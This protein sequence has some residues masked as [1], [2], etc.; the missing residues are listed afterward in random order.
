[1]FS[2]RR[3]VWAPLWDGRQW[4]DGREIVVRVEDVHEFLTQ[5][6]LRLV[7]RLAPYGTGFEVEVGSDVEAGESGQV[8]F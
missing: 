2:R 6:R 5:H 8:D 1:L 3:T 7:S 4:W